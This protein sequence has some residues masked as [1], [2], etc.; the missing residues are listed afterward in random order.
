MLAICCLHSELL[1]YL[2]PQPTEEGQISEKITASVWLHISEKKKNTDINQTVQ[3]TGF[4]VSKEK[5]VLLN[6]LIKAEL[7]L[8]K[9]KKLTFGALAF[10]VLAF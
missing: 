1:K 7:P 5:L 3:L 6:K 9:F 2:F 10:R 8:W 4:L